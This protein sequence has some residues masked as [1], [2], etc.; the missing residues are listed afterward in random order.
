MGNYKKIW[1][2]V[3]SR[4]PEND[5]STPGFPNSGKWW[6][7]GEGGIGDFTGVGDFFTRCWEPKE[8]W[9]WWFEPFSKLKTAFCENGTSIK[10]K[11]S[12]T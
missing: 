1:E 6:G 4:M 11:I 10:I 3:L 8:E 9:F 2:F 7:G 12:M 5:I